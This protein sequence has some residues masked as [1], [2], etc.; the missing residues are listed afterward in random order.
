MKETKTLV[1]TS[2]LSILLFTFH[3]AGDIILG[4]EKGNTS[5][6]PAFLIF[7]VWM[8][9]ALVL[10][11]RRSGHVIMFLGSLLS[12]AVPILHMRGKGL[13]V[14]G[15]IAT[16]DGALFFIWTIIALGTTALFSVVLS[17]RGLWR[18]RR[19]EAG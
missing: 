19:G 6:L 14:A 7:T 15:R 12:L 13:G 1:I 2:L 10:A 11:E 5:N 8:Y 3:L 16:S 17:A 9:G 18:L 4:I